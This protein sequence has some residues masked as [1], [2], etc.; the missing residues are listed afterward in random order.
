MSTGVRIIAT[1]QPGS[2][3]RTTVVSTQGARSVRCGGTSKQGRGVGA[4]FM[5]VLQFKASQMRLALP[6][7]SWRRDNIVAV[8]GS[9][10]AEGMEALAAE[11]GGG[12]SVAGFVSKATAPSG[13]AAGG[14]AA[15]L[16][17][18]PCTGT[19]ASLA[20]VL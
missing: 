13:R 7:L 18:M 10:A 2:G 6:W 8:F 14:A 3:S 20:C 16:C 17:T 5:G 4:Q 19:Q 9:K 11:V 15:G 1:N 12:V